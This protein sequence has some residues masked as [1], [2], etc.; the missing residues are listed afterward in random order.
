MEHLF[1]L[2]FEVFIPAACC[3]AFDGIV[4]VS[5]PQELVGM[6]VEKAVKMAQM[7]NVPIAA[8][9]ENMSYFVC[10]NCNEKH[11]IFGKSNLEEIA[12]KHNIDTIVRLEMNS[13]FAS[14]CDKGEIES[15]NVK[16]IE[17]IIKK[18]KSL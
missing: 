8:L 11:Y 15:A 3:A 9:V 1:F 5:S 12:K 10:P 2:P 6:I 7:M 14:L 16:E 4:F 17:P 18:L 13:S